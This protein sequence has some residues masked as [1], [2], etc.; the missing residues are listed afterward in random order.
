MSEYKERLR[1]GRISG[2]SLN[3]G[4]T[5]DNT[6]IRLRVD[7]NSSSTT[8]TNVID[9]PGYPSQNIILPGQILYGTG[10][11]WTDNITTII[12]TDPNNNTIT[13]ADAPTS[14]ITNKLVVVRL[15]KGQ[16]FIESGSLS[17]PAYSSPIWNY[18]SITGSEDSEYNEGDT[19]WAIITGLGTTSDYINPVVGRYGVYTITKIV[20]RISNGISSFYISASDNGIYVEGD[21]ST[22][23]TFQNAIAITE[24]ST[25][26]SLAP[27]FH[28]GDADVTEGIGLGAYQQTA[29]NFFDDLATD[30]LYT[31]SLVQ[32][33]IEFINF[34]GSGIQSIITS[35]DANGKTGVEITIQGGGGADDDWYIGD[36]FLTASKDIRITGSLLVTHTASNLDFFIIN[37][38]SYEAFK[39]NSEGVT[40]FFA[41]ADA[42]EPWATA[43]YGGLYFQ[44][45]SVWAALD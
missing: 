22:P 13:V 18:N 36:T 33:N 1:F 14:T 12:S 29:R 27:I 8:I 43:E 17:I 35:S 2:F 19:K 5:I 38:G 34:T 6:F 41:H 45:S 37:S 24:L 28:G 11:G 42:P 39:V 10:L 3:P 30:I 40:Q 44:S 16:S 26:S 23:A 21:D 20:D 7:T 15:P 32:G 4:G 25:S 9:Q 31:G